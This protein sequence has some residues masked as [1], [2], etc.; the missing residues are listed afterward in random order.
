MSQPQPTPAKEA[1]AAPAPAP[2]L[3]TPT[4]FGANTQSEPRERTPVEI[5]QAQPKGPPPVKSV[6]ANGGRFQERSIKQLEYALHVEKGHTI[7]DILKPSYWQHVASILKPM[8]KIAAMADDK[9]FYCELIVFEV[10]TGY[11]QV[12]LFGEPIRIT[13]L[14]KLRAPAL[15]FE[16][17]DGGLHLSWCVRMKSTGAIKKDSLPT[18]DAARAWL[19]DFLRSQKMAA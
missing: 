7:E 6:L 16:V 8:A 1:P 9:S 17:F 4:P 15:D 13:D 12:E 2:T 18:E 5:M 10:G 19:R 11:A 3:A 14:T